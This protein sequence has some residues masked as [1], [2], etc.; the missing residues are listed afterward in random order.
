MILGEGRELDGSSTKVTGPSRSSKTAEKACETNGVAIYQAL[1]LLGTTGSRFWDVNL[2]SGTLGF[3]Q[4]LSAKGGQPT[5][6]RTSSNQFVDV[7]V[8]SSLAM[9]AITSTPILID[10]RRIATN[11]SSALSYEQKE[12]SGHYH[13]N[14]NSSHDGLL[15]SQN[16]KPSNKFPR[17]GCRMRTIHHLL[18]MSGML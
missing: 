1:A 11:D 8:F 7:T 13:M 14:S 6:Q 9:Y 10:S 17:R 12:V 5:G 16:R 15:F 4:S 2:I 3:D 18:Q